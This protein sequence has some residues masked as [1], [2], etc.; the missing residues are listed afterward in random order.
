MA[1]IC[2]LYSSSKGN[3]TYIESGSGGILVD[4]GVSA[5][6]V[7]EGLNKIGVSPK[8]IKAVFVTH[9]HTDHISGIR[10]FCSKWGTRVYASRGTLEGMDKAGVFTKPVEAFVIKGKTE[11]D[12]VIVTPFKT[13]HDTLGP[14]N[15]TFTFENGKRFGIC[16]DLGVVTQEV[17]QALMG[18]DAVLLESNHE[19]DLVRMGVYPPALKRR[20]LSSTGHLSNEMCASFVGELYIGGT[21]KFILGHLSKENNY[22]SLAYET[23]AARL[24]T[25]IKDGD[26]DCF[27]TVAGDL[28]EPVEI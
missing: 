18:C 3:C 13:S 11:V 8:D 25:L 26:G 21:R 24:K 4:I 9:E 27:L 1:R 15:Y 28:N 10:A 20:I 2:S 22:P 23:T 12:G 19:P 17:R 5:K 16:T 7:E 14:C 6:K